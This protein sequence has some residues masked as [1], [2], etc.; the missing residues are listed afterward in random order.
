M[1][2]GHTLEWKMRIDVAS[3]GEVMHAAVLERGGNTD[4]D[5]GLDSSL[6]GA[7]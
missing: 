7:K 1:Q 5:S 2:P 4:I 6:D 3:R